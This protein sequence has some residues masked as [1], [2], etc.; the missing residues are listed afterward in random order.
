M[1]SLGRSDDK[2]SLLSVGYH[3]DQESKYAEKRGDTH[4]R[5]LSNNF[6]FALWILSPAAIAR[7]NRSAR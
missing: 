4:N 7:A 6:L 3:Q 1:V 2:I 5:I